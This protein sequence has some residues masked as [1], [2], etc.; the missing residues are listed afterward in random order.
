M[1]GERAHRDGGEE[2]SQEGGLTSWSLPPPSPQRSQT[3]LFPGVSISV[4]SYPTPRRLWASPQPSSIALSTPTPAPTLPVKFQIPCLN[5][6]FRS[7]SASPQPRLTFSEPKHKKR[8]FCL[9]KDRFKRITHLDHKL[10]KKAPTLC[11][12]VCERQQRRL[13]PH[14]ASG[15]LKGRVRG[16]GMTALA[17]WCPLYRSWLLPWPQQECEG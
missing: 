7:S 4:S 5:A 15:R 10:K 13:A 3:L 1:G 8:A 17:A 9:H 2:V 14:L 6:S 12:T 11:R 16:E